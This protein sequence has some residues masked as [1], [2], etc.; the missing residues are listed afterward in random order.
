MFSGRTRTYKWGARETGNHKGLWLL[1]LALFA[2]AILLAL[3]II[4]RNQTTYVATQ[5]RP[6]VLAPMEYHQAPVA[7]NRFFDATDAQAL[8]L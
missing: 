1:V 7:Y 2:L 3:L 6:T 5:A 8:S 4:A